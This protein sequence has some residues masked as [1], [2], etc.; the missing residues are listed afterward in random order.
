MPHPPP[1]PNTPPPILPYAPD[2]HCPP[3]N[4]PA[5]IAGL[6]TPYL[7]AIVA[8]SLIGLATA[9]RSAFEAFYAFDPP[10]LVALAAFPLLVWLIHR[11]TNRRGF[12]LGVMIGV[13][14]IPVLA[15]IAVGISFGHGV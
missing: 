3:L 5:L 1:N 11:R 14:S 6:I 13:A 9:R 8:M 2:P 10:V 15:L 12:L 4:I 7:Y